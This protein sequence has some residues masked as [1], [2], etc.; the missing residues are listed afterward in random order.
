MKKIQWGMKKICSP[1]GRAHDASC[2]GA[3]AIAESATK[4][5]GVVVAEAQAVANPVGEHQHAAGGVVARKL[6][7]GRKNRGL[8]CLKSVCVDMENFR[9]R[10]HG[11]ME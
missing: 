6:Q 3:G 1:W 4:F 11:I 5:L 10:F 8:R 9:C 2:L 7:S